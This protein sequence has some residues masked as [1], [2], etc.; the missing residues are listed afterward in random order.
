MREYTQIDE[1]GFADP[2][3]RYAS[4]EEIALADRLRQE[5]EKRYLGTESRVARR[6]E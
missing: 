3:P 1:D 5:I 2:P 4:A 6:T